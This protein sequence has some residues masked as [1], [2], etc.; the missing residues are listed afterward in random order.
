MANPEW[1]NYRP[2]TWKDHLVIAI[3]ELRNKHPDCT[4]LLYKSPQC[5]LW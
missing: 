1:D 5:Y 2:R 4:W 3:L